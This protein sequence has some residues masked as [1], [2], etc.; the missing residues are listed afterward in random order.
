[1]VFLA[2]LL[3]CDPAAVGLSAGGPDNA[4]GDDTAR[5]DAEVAPGAT[6]PSPADLYDPDCVVRYDLEIAEADWDAMQQA[7]DRAVAYCG[8]TATLRDKHPATLVYGHER[9]EVGVRLKGNPCTFLAGGKMQFRVDVDWV[10]PGNFHDVSSINLEAANYDPTGQKNGLAY[11]VF[12]DVG[13]VASQ[14]NF[15]SLYVNGTFYGVYENVEQVNGQFLD[16]HYDDSSGN[17][18][19]F[20]WNGHYGELRSNEEVGDVSRWTE[21]E[22][23]VNATPDTV[24]WTEFEARIVELVDIDQLLLAFATEAVIPQVDG[25]WAGSAN[26]YVYD[27]PLG[28]GGAGCFEYLPWDLDSAFIAPP[29]DL[30]PACG[31]EPDT[32]TADPVS[33]ISGRGPAAKW[34][35]FELLMELPG[36]RAQFV[37]DLGAVL[38]SAYQV[39][40][41]QG[42]HAA[43][44]AQLEPY[45]AVDPKADYDRFVESNAELSVFFAERRAFVEGWIAAQP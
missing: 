20:I 24:S 36:R 38:E 3:A 18:Y 42:R 41:L 31:S 15:A 32:V 16:N 33:F 44:F 14:A 37:T 40:V 43:R 25:V 29:L 2:A 21:M 35:L 12:R 26:C 11:A 39:D 4:A 22:A 19:Y 23:L 17:L 8:D 34:R 30:C 27:N 13:L 9:R 10:E 6:C 28:C 1:M 45:M 7:Y 5:P